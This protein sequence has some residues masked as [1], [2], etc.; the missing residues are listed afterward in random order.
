LQNS[1]LSQVLQN[2]RVMTVEMAIDLL[3]ALLQSR[4]NSS[5]VDGQITPDRILIISEQPIYIKI[6]PADNIGAD[7]EFSAPEI[8][9][10]EI[11]PSSDLYSIG[12]ITIYLLTGIRPFQLFDMAN[13]CWVWQDYWQI[14]IHSSR[15]NYP[16]LAAILD[17]SI[18]LDPDLRFSSTREMMMAVRDC[19][20]NLTPTLPNWACRHTLTGHQGLFAAITTIAISP[21]L[22]LVATGSEDMTIRLWNIES[23]ASI[24]I[25]TGHQKSVETIAFHPHQ[26]G[27]LFSGDRS[28]QIKLWQ[29]DPAEELV[30]IDSQQG[31]INCLAISPDGKLIISGGSDRTIKIWYF[32]LSDERSIDYLVTLK[33]H[34]LAVN[35]IA[36][37]PIESTVKFASV[38]SD[39]RVIL[40]G[41]ESKTPLSILKSH[42]QAVK[43]LAF[44]PDG[45]LLATAGDD[46]LIQ[47]WDVDSRKLVQT[48][49]AHRWT[50]SSLSFMVDGAT[51]ISTSWDGNIKFW[52]VISGAEIDY[53]SVH[54]AEVLAMEICEHR[55][56]I[57]TAS[58]DRTAKIWGRIF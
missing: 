18:D 58:R 52:N 53:L 7:P 11:S 19:V 20:P 21:H 36:F 24:G 16:K 49:S 27:L 22:P 55:Q 33:A 32:G 57:V 41:M 25:L 29:I 13:C 23:G 2:D 9:A 17:R 1:S 45:K 26:S 39:R 40:W 54:A 30:S 50:I 34:Q 8:F 51:I 28:G 4:I 43:T 3:V 6:L 10:S 15:I 42:T 56:C 37:N 31:K 5:E 46:G 14:P 47:L 38:S 44:S 12:L 48:I 35:R